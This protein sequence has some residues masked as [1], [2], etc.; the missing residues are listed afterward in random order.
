MFI[1][2]VLLCAVLLGCHS[3]L[4]AAAHPKLPD[5]Y[6]HWLNEEVVSIITDEEKKA[7]LQ[8]GTNEQRDRFIEEFWDV[9]NPLRG[10]NQ[11]PYKLEFYARREY[12]DAHFGRMSHTPGSL[13]DMGRTWIL[14][15]K[16]ESSF[17]FTGYSQLYPIALWF[18]SNK[19]GNPSLPPFFYVLFYIPE[20]IG[21]Y[22][23]YRPKMD[24]PMQLVRGSRI[25]SNA[26]VF[27]FLSPI[28]GDLARAAFSLIP[29]DPVDT[30]TFTVDLASDMLVSKL[31]NFAND[32]YNVR[33][34]HQ[35]RALQTSVS[36]V[37]LASA[38]QK[39]DIN[40]ITLTDPVG[41]SWLDYSVAIDREELGRKG[42]DG[43]F[44]LDVAYRLLTGS[45]NLIVEDEVER[46]FPAYQSSSAFRPFTLAERLP[47]VP[48]SYRLE[49]QVVNR[50][51]GRIYRGQRDFEVPKPGGLSLMGPLVANS[52]DRVAA[53]SSITPFQYFGVQFHVP[54]KGQFSLNQ[55]L[56]V[57]Y[58]LRAPSP[59]R[60]Y[61]VDYV[62]VNLH[63]RDSRRQMTDRIAQA[64]FN[65]QML[66]KSKTIPI[67]GLM[68]GDYMLAINVRNA[69]TP[70]V[71]ISAN[72]TLRV[73][74]AAGEQTMFF[75]GAEQKLLD[76]GVA[77]YLRGLESIA[78]R[79][80]QGALQFLEQ[81]VQHN[82]ANTFAKQYLIQLY[83]RKRAYQ[84]ITTL[85]HSSQVNEFNSS[86]EVLAQISFSLWQTG[87]RNQ[88]QQLLRT[89]RAQFPDNPILSATAKSLTT[90]Q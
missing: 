4:V 27:K 54:A 88:A 24:G 67:D 83:F 18:Y 60:D 8:L 28:G 75:L 59:V 76:P 19:T 47:I 51:A 77:N 84:S 26:D 61:D 10:S 39:L 11:N 87:D 23:Y 85:F 62:L 43:N 16:P 34:L 1:R 71:L 9:R 69:G 58:Q 79:D 45:G 80:E 86:P 6:R 22:R 40:T 7:F 38:E 15:G 74:D 36:S 53:P 72:Q 73:A 57:L 29:N 35:M 64:E 14:F 89:A 49:L 3:R 37:F 21:E 41:L 90:N 52:V 56:R 12:A 50:A 70:Q 20:N 68:A 66:L 55:P 32:P 42:N 13:T 46:S 17:E 81:A 65:N 5:T 30:Q 63:S 78:S 44:I 25:Q 33:K 48:G 31:Q 82:S 2:V